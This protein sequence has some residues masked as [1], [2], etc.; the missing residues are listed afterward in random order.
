[1]GSFRGVLFALVAP[2][3]RRSMVVLAYGH[4]ASED[5]ETW[6]WFMAN[7]KEAYPALNS[8]STVLISDQDKGL[9]VAARTVLPL[10][11]HVLCS[12]HRA[13]N[14]RLRCGRL[15]ESV[16]QKAA[17]ATTEAD[18]QA[19]VAAIEA[20]P[21]DHRAYILSVSPERWAL[22]KA[23]V[24]RIGKTSSQ[25]AEAF[26]AQFLEARCSSV[27]RMVDMIYANVLVS[28]A[29]QR[30][31]YA[32]QTEIVPRAV[33]AGG[34]EGRQWRGLMV[35]ITGE[36]HGSVEARTESAR[37]HTVD[38]NDCTCSCGAYQIKGLPCVHARALALH[39]GKDLA[40]CTHEYYQSSRGRSAYEAAQPLTGI[41]TVDLEQDHLLPP[42]TRRP[43]GRPTR[44]RVPSRGEQQPR[45][46]RCTLCQESGHNRR[47]CSNPNPMVS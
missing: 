4:S 7:C 18:Y 39:V 9:D 10:A 32:S 46:R 33:A 20:L 11:D 19:A 8:A 35:R 23:R 1:M 16:F 34:S 41:V 6:C 14:I 26:N 3:C 12:L 29:E 38:L 44:R 37:F 15:A 27:F 13:R 24:F 43:R 17:F 22:A 5:S 31:Y 36:A 42:H 40:Q 21:P 25:L 28:M 30:Q 45:L 47:T 2:D